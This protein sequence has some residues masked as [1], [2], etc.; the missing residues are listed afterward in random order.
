MSLGHTWGLQMLRR[1][2]QPMGGDNQRSQ[3]GTPTWALQ[4]TLLL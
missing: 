1:C 4:K 2:T 3:E